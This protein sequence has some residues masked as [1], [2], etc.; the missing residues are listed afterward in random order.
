M[1]GEFHSGAS[2]NGG[3]M[4][5]RRERAAGGAGG[6]GGGRGAAADGV[7]GLGGL[8]LRWRGGVG[9][10]G[11][12]GGGFEV[13]RVRAA[14]AEV[15]I[16][17]ACFAV[18]VL[19]GIVSQDLL[20]VALRAD[21]DRDILE[22]GGLA[23]FMRGVAPAAGGIGHRAVDVLEAGSEIFVAFHAAVVG[24][25]EI[26]DIAG[27]VGVADG[28]LAIVVGLVAG[29]DDG[30]KDAGFAGDRRDGGDLRGASGLGTPSKKTE[31][32]R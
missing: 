14:V 2:L 31:R 25:V 20:I 6:N 9:C 28:A 24:L 18:G 15:A 21:G 1:H 13:I 4:G 32:T 5:A 22:Q 11:I 7:G 16:E 30:G 29:D 27:G 17:A 3:V 19:G 12:R 26:L 8:H 10:G 23:G